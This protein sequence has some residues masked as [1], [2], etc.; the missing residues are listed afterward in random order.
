[1]NCTHSEL[2]AVTEYEKKG[3]YTLSEKKYVACAICN[4]ILPIN[5]ITKK[6]IIKQVNNDRIYR[7]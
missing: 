1:M 6:E 2:L 4:E 3:K 5:A 7:K